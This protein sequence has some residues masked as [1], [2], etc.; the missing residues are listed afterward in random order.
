MIVASTRARADFVSI[1]RSTSAILFF[2]T[3]YHTD[4]KGISNILRYLSGV[5][6]CQGIR[7][8]FICESQFQRNLDDTS[9]QL[10]QI[11]E[12]FEHLR[13]QQSSE[14]SIDYFFEEL[15]VANFGL[16]SGEGVQEKISI[17]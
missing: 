9:A 8:D 1:K 7:E 6:K 12:D 3:P 13:V 15:P 2:A 10:R 16:V 5:R 4:H 11:Q 14:F 17:N